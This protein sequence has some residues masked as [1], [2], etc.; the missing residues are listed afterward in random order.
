MDMRFL[1][2]MNMPS[3][4]NNLVHQMTVEHDSKSLD[5]FV[6]ALSSN[7][8]VI[9]EEFYKDPRTDAD[10][11]SRGHVALNYRYIGKIKVLTHRGALNE[12]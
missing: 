12:R 8:F 7:E 1:I 11:Y 2:T 3:Y 4:S 6:E 9:V 10:Y 5:D